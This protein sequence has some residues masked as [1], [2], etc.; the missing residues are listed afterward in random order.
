PGGSVTD[1]LSISKAIRDAGWDT[2]VR[3]GSLCASSCPLILSGGVERLVGRQAAVGVHQVFTTQN[4]QR[5][6]A[7]SISGTQSLTAEI[8]RHLQAMGVETQVWVHAL[9]TPPQYLYYFTPEE[10]AEFKL[11]TAMPAA[12]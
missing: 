6:N 4:D 8:T 1:A 2:Q 5:S 11:A 12:L 3:S 10:L 9:E 7:D